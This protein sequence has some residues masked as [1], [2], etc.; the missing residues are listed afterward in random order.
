MAASRA[1]SD[2]SRQISRSVAVDALSQLKLDFVPPI[3]VFRPSAPNDGWPCI[4]A[5]ISPLSRPR[6]GPTSRSR[7]KLGIRCFMMLGNNWRE[8][9]VR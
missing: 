1:A 8:P 5:G 7:C 3:S 6:P 2:G 9:A 4:I